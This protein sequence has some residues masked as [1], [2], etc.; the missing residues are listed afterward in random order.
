MEGESRQEGGQG[1][2]AVL[3][4]RVERFSDRCEFSA[5]VFLR[6]RRVLHTGGRLN[7]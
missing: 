7:A 5:T 2:E 4:V 1:Q 3:H 6:S